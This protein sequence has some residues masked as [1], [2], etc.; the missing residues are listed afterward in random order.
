MFRLCIYLFTL[1]VLV[2]CDMSAPLPATLQ[3][4]APTPL[5][6]PTLPPTA[7][8]PAGVAT[9]PPTDSSVRALL[10]SV[11]SDRLMITVGTLVDQR[12]RYVL[13]HGASTAGGIDGARDWLVNQFSAIRDG[14]SQQPI[15]V[16]AQPVLFTWNGARVMSENVALVFQGTDV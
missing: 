4:Q 3:V 12:T 2:S 8:I 1:I 16:W 13:S 9:A 10:D 14:S 15:S 7:L 11:Q 6:T 5:P